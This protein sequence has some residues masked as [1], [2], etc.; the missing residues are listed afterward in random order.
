ML[1]E[2]ENMKLNSFKIED[3]DIDA[4][5]EMEEKYS[6]IDT[7]ECKREHPHV[8]EFIE[9]TDYLSKEQ[10]QRFLSRKKQE[11]FS[12]HHMGSETLYA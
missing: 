10:L 6:N 7:E 4:V 12:R 11:I 8:F 5:H 9:K 2:L 1:G 3:E